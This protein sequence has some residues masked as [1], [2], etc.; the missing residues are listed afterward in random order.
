[1]PRIKIEDIRR[2]Q[3]VEAAWEV[4]QRQGAAGTTLQRVADQAGVS[5]GIVLHYF[6]NKDALIEN[7]MRHVNLLLR[8]HVVALLRR[9]NS[10]RARIDAV[11][12]GNFSPEFFRPEVAHAWLALCSAVPHNKQFARVQTAIHRRMHSNLMSGLV[13]MMPRREATTVALGIS[14]LI[15]GLWLRCGLQTG[16]IDRAHALEQ[17]RLYLAN[18]VDRRS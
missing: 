9:A 7:A 4:L 15:D 2:R 8:D 14:A 13:A 12:E 18:I 6:S 11:V 10:P 16:G 1:M 17:M 3:L 5:K